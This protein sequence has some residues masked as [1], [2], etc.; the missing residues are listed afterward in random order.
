MQ[1]VQPGYQ[2]GNKFRKHFTVPTSWGNKWQGWNHLL[3]AGGGTLELWL[4][5]WGEGF[6]LRCLW[7]FQEGLWDQDS[8]LWAGRHCMTD[9]G[10]SESPWILEL[11]FSLLKRGFQP[12][13]WLCC[14]GSEEADW[15][16]FWEF[17]KNRK[18]ILIAVTGRNCFWKVKWVLLGWYWNKKQRERN[19]CLPSLAFQCPFSISLLDDPKR[20]L[21]IKEETCFAVTSIQHHKA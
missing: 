20:E 1:K 12:T 4:R 2:E 17:S 11:G 9:A 14:L 8:D 6:L 15:S 19:M 16:W 21:G 7:S 5:P 13:G 3:E 10:A 18:W